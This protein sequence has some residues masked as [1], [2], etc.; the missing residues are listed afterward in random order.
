MVSSPRSQDV[1]E[2]IA[3]YPKPPMVPLPDLDDP[4]NY[5]TLVGTLTP[6]S[7]RLARFLVKVIGLRE[8]YPELP[9]R[10]EQIQRSTNLRLPGLYAPVIS[11]TINLVDDPRGLD[12]YQ[13]A[14][15]LLVGARQLC[16]DI[17][18][19]TLPPDTLR[20]QPIEMGQYPNLFG[21]CLDVEN[22]QAAMF[23][24]SS[25]DT[26]TIMLGGRV[27]QL[28]VGDLQDET[29]AAQLTTALQKL[30]ESER[31]V[32]DDTGGPGPGLLTSASDRTQIQAFSQM[33][34]DPQSHQ[35]LLA[36][37]HS[38]LTVCLDLDHSPESHPEAA[39][40]A[41]VGNPQ[42]RWHH[43]SLQLVVF[44][45]GKAC[46]LCN[47]TC[48]LDGNV[49]MR[50]AAEIQRR[51]A[52]CPVQIENGAALEALPPPTR[53]FFKLEPKFI[54]RARQDLQAVVDT[55]QATFEIEGFGRRDFSA[56]GLSAVQIFILGL[57]LAGRRLTGSTPRVNQFLSMNRYRCMDLFPA[58]LTTPEVEA[59]VAYLLDDPLDSKQALDLIRQATESQEKASRFA[60]SQLSV[61]V[62]T[63]FQILSMK[64]GL[65]RRF[66]IYLYSAMLLFFKRRG[67]LK[68]IR[69]DV[70]VSFPEIFPE[71]P[72]VGRPGVRLPYV[73][74]YSLHY[75]IF[76][77]K[78]V[79]T[80]MPGVN[81]Q[82]SN[83]EL[84]R[85][86][87]QSLNQIKEIIQQETS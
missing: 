29:S 30:G 26:L 33:H 56:S 27:Y 12:P 45:N 17:F 20:G 39:R 19:G 18:S 78:T 49:M 73:R 5:Q 64:K 60:R 70:L 76:D 74:Q 43:A 35:S 42:N 16:N 4:Q 53:L 28:Q 87:T 24:N 15:T 34:A 79:I 36:L 51:A 21:T 25:F 37:R 48:Y 7:M 55:Q 46:A 47:F 83:Q 38:L 72:L 86:I 50:G 69:R 32:P 58:I 52:A 54:E 9:E 75:Q 13:R 77:D 57:A 8:A 85:V 14:A 2:Q 65:R 22:G 81:W 44:G 71:T 62:L 63:N 31:G 61:G 3:A 67:Y 59:C 68:P 1:Y 84:T 6:F 41:Q 40:L 11:A 66:S 23:K 82:T 10:I 80:Y